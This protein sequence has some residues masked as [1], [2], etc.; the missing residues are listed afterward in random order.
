VEVKYDTMRG[1]WCSREVGGTFGVGVW[2]G[3]RRGWDNFK[4]HAQFKVGDDSRVL[5]W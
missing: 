5:F 4:Q 3:I 1:G 2:K